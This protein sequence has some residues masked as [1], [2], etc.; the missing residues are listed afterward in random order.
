MKFIATEDLSYTDEYGTQ[1]AVAGRTIVDSESD[2]YRLHSRAFAPVLDAN[3][4]P[5]RWRAQDRYMSSL[6]GSSMRVVRSRA[7]PAQPTLRPPTRPVS[8]PTQRADYGR[9]AFRIPPSSPECRGSRKASRTR[10]R[11]DSGCYRDALDV[12]QDTTARDGLE[13]GG[14]L[15]APAIDSTLIELMAASGPGPNAKRARDSFT[16]D[17]A[18]DRQM[19]AEMAGR[20]LIVCG[21]W[22][23]HPNGWR[24][25]SEA[26]LKAHSLARRSAGASRWVALIAVPGGAEGL[27]LEAFVLRDGGNGHD[28]C[29]EARL[30]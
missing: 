9:E 12:F 17:P 11:L 25:M 6:D 10:L 28:I 22:H 30:D 1:E 16:N 24:A 14:Q 18:Y 19:T 4:E 23:S 5:L 20:G 29:E 3:G 8:A 15:F 13:A 27:E 2:M 26:D 21:S 7:A